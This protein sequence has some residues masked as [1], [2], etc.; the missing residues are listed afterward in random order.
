MLHLVFLGQGAELVEIAAHQ[1]W[2]GDDG[3]VRP[4]FYPALF[5]DRQD[6]A[7]QVLVGSHP[8]GDPVHNDADSVR[9][10]LV[11][12]LP[13]ARTRGEGGHNVPMVGVRAVYTARGDN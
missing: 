9:L 4:Q 2:F 7:D 8:S 13:S 11:P 1:D 3:L 5:A 12:L 10:H 6:R